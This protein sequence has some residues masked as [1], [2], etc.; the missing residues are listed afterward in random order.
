MRLRHQFKLKLDEEQQAALARIGIHLPIGLATLEVMEDDPQWPHVQY[1]AQQFGFID[2]IGTEFSKDELSAA[3]SLVIGAW[4]NGFPQPERNYAYLSQTYDLTD[5][6]SKCGLGRVQVAP[7]LIKKPPKWGSKAFFQLSWVFDEL[8]VRP[9]V[10]RE[11]FYPLSIESWPVILGS[12]GELCSDVLQLKISRSIDLD[13]SQEIATSCNVCG[14]TKYL[15][16][17]VGFFPKP[18][19]IPDESL[20]RSVEYFGYNFQVYRQVMVTQSMHK[21]LKDSHPEGLAFWPCG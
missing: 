10:Y 2:S 5:A 11:V 3:S 12:T 6:C 20:F 21:T 8:F 4:E 15:P 7:F 17:S 18:K 16:H 1:L 19:E 9:D 13:C 14:R